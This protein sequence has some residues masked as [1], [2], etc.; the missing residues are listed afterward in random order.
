M[1]KF[2]LAT[3]WILIVVFLVILAE[4]FIPAV[5]DLFRGSILFLMPL[6]IFFLLGA[7][8]LFLAIKG[9]VKGI[10]KKFLILTGA[11]AAGFFV[12]VFLHNAFY[13]LGVITIDITVL[14]Y[15]M[16]AVSVIFFLIAI[17]ACPVGF[18]IGAVG[19]ITI[20]IKKDR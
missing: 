2:L 16:E 7:L 20:L 11:S 1:K 19:S 12:C 3:F 5:R 13:A 9:S 10:L 6:I 14:K 15:L 8:L 4:F 17:F 18:L